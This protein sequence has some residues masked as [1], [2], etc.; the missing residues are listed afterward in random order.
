MISMFEYMFF[1]QAEM[2]T[3]IFFLTGKTE[4]V[5]ALGAQLG[6]LVLVFNCDETFDFSAMGRLFAGLSQGKY[7]FLPRLHSGMATSQLTLT[8]VWMQTAKI[9]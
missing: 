7:N 8:Q 9:G 2:R 4:S 1:S 5:K 6:R 3:R